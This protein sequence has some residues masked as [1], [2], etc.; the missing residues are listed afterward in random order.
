MSGKSSPSSP[1]S[2]SL[3]VLS[4]SLSSS[5]LTCI[6]FKRTLPVERCLPEPLF[7]QRAYYVFPHTTIKAS[8]TYQLVIYSTAT[9]NLTIKLEGLIN[10]HK[11]F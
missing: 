9:N 7:T 5:F 6:E 4:S 2:S 8:A 11:K 1:S 3:S 10:H